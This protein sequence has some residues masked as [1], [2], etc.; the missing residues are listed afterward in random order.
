MGA[1]L[2]T[3]FESVDF[4]QET[5]AAAAANLDA[6]EMREPASLIRWLSVIAE[7]RMRDAAG[8]LSADKRDPGPQERLDETNAA[9]RFEPAEPGP[10]PPDAL[11]RD[12]LNALV[13]RCVAEL[14]PEWQEVILLREYEGGS[15]KYVAERLRKSVEAAQ[16]LHRRARE[17]LAQALERHGAF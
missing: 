6:F 16:A 7:Y 11:E 5:L 3:G 2:R 8:W 9:P 13:D 12:E 1:R 17:V 10:S 15:W 4:V 14:K